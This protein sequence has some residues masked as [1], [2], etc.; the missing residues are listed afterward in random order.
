MQLHG[1]S[2]HHVCVCVCVH[3]AAHTSKL[4]K[5]LMDHLL[6]PASD[7]DDHYVK[8]ILNLVQEVQAGLKKGSAEAQL[9]DKNEL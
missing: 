9:G 8:Y 5:H 4:Y 3:A 7:L 2:L 6:E 1:L